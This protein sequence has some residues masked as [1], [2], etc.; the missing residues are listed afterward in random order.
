MYLDAFRQLQ[1]GKI[2]ER[3]RYLD[4]HYLL[5]LDGTGY[6]SSNKI[7]CSSCLEKIH[8]NGNVTYSHQMLGA[9][10][11]HPALKEVIPLAPEPIIRQ[12]GQ[13]K[14][15][16]ERNS[17]RRFLKRFREEHP[18]LP[19]IVLEDSLASNSPHI[20]DLRNANAHYILGVKKGDHAFL[21]EK[22]AAAEI[23]NQ[24]QVLTLVESETSILHHFRFYNSIPLNASNTHQLVNVLEYWEIQPDKIVKGKKREGAITHFSW[25][26]DFKLS[27]KNVYEVMRGGRSRWKIENEVFN[28]LK[29]QGYNLEH[30]Y[31]HGKKNLSVLLAMIMMLAFLEDQIQQLCSPLFQAAWEKI[32]SKRGLWEKMRYLFA[33]YHFMSM[34]ELFE[35]MVIGLILQRP[36]F[37]ANSS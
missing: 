28:T 7:H 24:T 6:F 22:L 35:A 33:A 21:F 2:L 4:G 5:S 34:Q 23:A 10:L 32:G 1:R 12:D 29:N 37:A 30:N 15:D 18:H 17:A 8:K 13:N 16:C 36:V 26:T 20:D 31:G 11:L 14:N 25:V 19:V 9:V 3:F 27:E